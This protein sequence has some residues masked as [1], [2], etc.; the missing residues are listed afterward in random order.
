MK[1][2][3]GAGSELCENSHG[4]FLGLRRFSGSF[5]VEKPGKKWEKG[6]IFPIPNKVRDEEESEPSP[7]IPAQMR[8]ADLGFPRDLNTIWGVGSDPNL[9][10]R[11]PGGQV[12]TGGWF[13]GKKGRKC[14]FGNVSG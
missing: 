2:G 14:W 5:G 11:D 3:V 1:D 8:E 4:I 10:W 6:E 12:G 7:K 13:F 9:S